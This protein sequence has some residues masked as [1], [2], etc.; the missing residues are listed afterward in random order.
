MLTINIE[1]IVIEAT[2]PDESSPLSPAW[3]DMVTAV[4]VQVLA[5][6]RCSVAAVLQDN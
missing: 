2:V 6:V 1:R 4:L 3:W 5:K